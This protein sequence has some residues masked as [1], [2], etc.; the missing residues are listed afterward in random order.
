MQHAREAEK[1]LLE[2]PCGPD[3][4][5]G[6]SIATATNSF[7]YIHPYKTISMRMKSATITIAYLY[8]A[9]NVDILAKRALPGVLEDPKGSARHELVASTCLKC[10]NS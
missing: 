1:E 3:V 9:R 6:S 7:R 5:H 10:Y 4:V 8:A 2:M